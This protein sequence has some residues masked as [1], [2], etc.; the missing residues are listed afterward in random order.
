[1]ASKVRKK[2]I[3]FGLNVGFH[4]LVCLELLGSLLGSFWGFFRFS[5]EVSAFKNV[6]KT[7]G[8]LRFMS[9]LIFG[10][11]SA[12]DALFGVISLPFYQYSS[13][14]EFKLVFR[15]G[16]DTI[17]TKMLKTIPKM[18]KILKQKMFQFSFKM[19]SPP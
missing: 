8:F 17:H 15:K 12:S 11:I 1:M 3:S 18:C 2:I 13:S 7:N 5:L 14:K 19:R 10:I 4:L 9:Q 16:S 6:V